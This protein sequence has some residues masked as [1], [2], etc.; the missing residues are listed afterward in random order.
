VP[1]KIA[2]GIDGSAASQAAVQWASAEARIRS[3]RVVAI[4]VWSY[5]PITAIGDPGM[6][7]IAGGDLPGQLE[8]E[9][10]AAEVQLDTALAAAF[11]D[12]IPG[13]LE[14]RLVEGDAGDALVAEAGD[15]DLIVVGSRGHGGLTSA[16]VGSVSRHVIHHAGCPV[17]VVKAPTES[18]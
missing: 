8:A 5:M 10:T 12:G 16:I 6:V 7:P 11:P 3:A 15:A 2:V 4:H 18:G 14:R 1:G 13:E 17:V 9:R